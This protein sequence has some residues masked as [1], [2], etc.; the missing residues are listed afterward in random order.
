[1]V[2]SAVA[3]LVT[4]VA[5]SFLIWLVYRRF[6][7]KI[8]P[9]LEE[10]VNMLPG[11]NCGACGFTGC[12]N[13]AEALVKGDNIACPVMGAGMDAVYKVLGRQ[14]SENRT[15]KAVVFCGAERDKKTFYAEYRGVESC[16]A[17]NMYSAYQS[18]G[19]GCLGF[20]DCRKVCPS[21]AIEI[22]DGV[23]VVNIDRCIG[24][25]LC[26]KECPRNIIKLVE[27]K[28]DF[29]PLVACSN[30]D[31][32]Q[33]VKKACSVGCIGCGIC[34]KTGPDGGFTL[35]ENLAEI[36]YNKVG[37]FEEELWKKTAEKC[38]QKT[39]KIKYSETRK[40]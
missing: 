32:A 19:Y 30:K 8:D 36:D 20:G 14:V 27:K 24:C 10:T 28:K 31:K 9:V 38:P 17:A 15:F 2:F 29:L 34:V 37:Y 23:A 35:N 22:I 21:D 12:Q 16:R 33:D 1:M 4:A 7:I 25:G 40:K 39:I 3:M 6:W 11:L 13:F 26:I 5:F 18:C